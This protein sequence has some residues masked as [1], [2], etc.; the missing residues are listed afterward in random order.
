MSRN[1]PISTSRIWASLYPFVAS[2]L[3]AA[4]VLEL[5]VYLVRVT[6]V[7]DLMALAII[8]YGT[9][10]LMLC[11]FSAGRTTIKE[12]IAIVRSFNARSDGR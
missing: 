2:L 7:I 9:T 8:A 10:L 3:G 11:C 5:Y 1:G 4:A 12:G 6:N